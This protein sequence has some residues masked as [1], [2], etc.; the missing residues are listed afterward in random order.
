MMLV[1]L[2]CWRHRGMSR[3]AWEDVARVATDH[4]ALGP[5]YTCYSPVL[6]DNE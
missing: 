2:L 5:G 4:V 6:R 1:V 3:A